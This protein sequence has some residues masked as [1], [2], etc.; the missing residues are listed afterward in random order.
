MRRNIHK[1]CD[2]E[3]ES[4]DSSAENN[5][6]QLVYEEYDKDKD[7]LSNNAYNDVENINELVKVSADERSHISQPHTQNDKN[8]TQTQ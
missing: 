1:N 2:V 7:E 3:E 4:E 5:D 8:N 6:N